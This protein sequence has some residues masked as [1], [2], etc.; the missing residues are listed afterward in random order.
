MK[1]LKRIVW[2]AAGTILVAKYVINHRDEKKK[3]REHRMIL[4]L[5]IGSDKRVKKLLEIEEVKQLKIKFRKHL[6][7]KEFCDTPRR[8]YWRWSATVNQIIL[9]PLDKDDNILPHN[10]D[11]QLFTLAH[12]IGHIITKT[13][14]LSR[15][16]QPRYNCLANELKAHLMA[17]IILEKV[18]VRFNKSFWKLRLINKWSQCQECLKTI[19]K[20]KCP[21]KEQ[22]KIKKCLKIIAQ[23][24]KSRESNPLLF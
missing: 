15:C 2:F 9:V 10:K 20:G 14:F 21:K 1:Y 8:R 23:N 19:N 7:S 11:R 12:E 5:L 24:I 17:Q 22:E 3:E 13:V 18:D 4:D 6:Q 16:S